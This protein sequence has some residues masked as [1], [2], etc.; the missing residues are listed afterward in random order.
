MGPGKSRCGAVFVLS[1]ALL[2]GGCAT[3][4][5][6]SPQPFPQVGGAGDPLGW[7]DPYRVTGTAL[8]LRGVPYV[9]GGDSPAGFDCSGFTRYV[10]AR[11]G[12]RLPRQAADQYEVGARVDRGDVRA[13][14]LVFFTTIASGA[15]HVG[16]ALGDDQFVH[17]PSERGVVRVERLTGSYWSRR[18]VGAR[19]VIGGEAAAAE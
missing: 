13:G 7:A 12:I 1:G 11:H 19:R 9:W 17:A 3:A 18:W 15:S 5:R 8:S 4:G 10:Y 14:D 2:A 16:L 6:H